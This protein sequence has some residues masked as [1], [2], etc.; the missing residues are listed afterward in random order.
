M[1]LTSLLA[2]VLLPVV[3]AADEPRP[4]DGAFGLVALDAIPLAGVQLY[5]HPPQEFALPFISTPTTAEGKYV[6]PS[7]PAGTYKVVVMPVKGRKG[8]AF[9]EKYTDP[10]TSPLK[11]TILKEATRA[12]IFL[13]SK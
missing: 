7:V 3:A 11:V 8:P 1:R 2:L 6:A 12:D 13:S 5:F 10:A 4:A 9:P